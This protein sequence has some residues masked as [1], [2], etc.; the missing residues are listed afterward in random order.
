MEEFLGLCLA[1]FIIRIVLKG[2]WGFWSSNDY[3][4]D[5]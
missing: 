2:L 4:R 5:R 3:R 1:V